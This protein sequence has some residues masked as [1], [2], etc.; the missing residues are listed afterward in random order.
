MKYALAAL[1]FKNGNVDY[2]QRVIIDTL[3]EYK[4]SVDMVVF[5]EAFLQG[6]YGPTFD[7]DHDLTLA[8]RVEDPVINEIQQAARDYGVAVSFGFIEKNGPSFY[9]S[10]ITIDAKGQTLDFFRRVSPGWKEPFASDRYQEGQGFHHFYF[11]NKRLVVGLCGDF[12]DETAPERVRLLR[13]DLVLWPVYLD[14]HESKWNHSEKLEYAQQ[15]QEL[16]DKV[17]L[18]NSYCL[19]DDQ[20]NQMAK[21]G[22]AAFVQGRIEKELAAGQPGV[23]VVEC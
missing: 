9:S 14:L 6:F 3:I 10:Q 21:G 16:C 15:A 19:D 5:G 2:N 22:A 4:H 17:L 20:E 12:W 18:V 8:L 11:Q 1:G 23:L 13:P 7:E